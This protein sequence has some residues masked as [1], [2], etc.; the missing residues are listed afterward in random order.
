MLRHMDLLF[1]RP[2]LCLRILIIVIKF[3]IL[4]LYPF[5]LGIVY[6]I[7]HFVRYAKD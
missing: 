7:A 2:S 3:D 6:P 4:D 5:L 1:S